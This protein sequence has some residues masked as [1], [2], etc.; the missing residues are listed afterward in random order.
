MSV[1]G[2]ELSRQLSEPAGAGAASMVVCRVSSS[3]SSSGIGRARARV[4]Q[5]L[6]HSCRRACSRPRIWEAVV[7]VPMR[8]GPLARSD[9]GR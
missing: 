7:S 2:C 8:H 6:E 5:N 9:R 3:L 1:M 4:V